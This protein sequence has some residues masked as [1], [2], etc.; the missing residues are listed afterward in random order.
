MVHE[1]AN[2]NQLIIGPSI[3]FTDSKTSKLNKTQHAK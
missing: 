2:M 3:Q 1:N